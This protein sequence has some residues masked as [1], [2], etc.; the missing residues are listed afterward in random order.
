MAWPKRS[1]KKE[2]PAAQPSTR[3]NSTNVGCYDDDNACIVRYETYSDFLKVAEEHSR[4]EDFRTSF[5]GNETRE[6][7]IRY[8]RY[9]N[10]ALVENAN[11]LMDKLDSVCGGVETSQWEPSPCG[12]YPIVPEYL[13][14]SPT[15][16]RQMLPC[17]ELSPVKIYVCTTSSALV[18][19]EN[20]RKRGIAILAL[21][22]K[23]QAIRPVELYVTAETDGNG[24]DVIQV[25]PI[26]SKP[27]SLAH[28]TY[29]LTSAGFARRLTY[30]IAYGKYACM[31]GWGTMYDRL[32]SGYPEWLKGQLGCGPSDLYIKSANCDDDMLSDPVAW[33][34][35]E[36]ER[37]RGENA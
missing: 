13:N 16:M 20:L 17:G 10:E 18:S 25:I 33:V 8:A 19:A 1:K 37:F 34:N 6:E 21:V 11:K 27:L 29:C 23:L 35:R 2:Q 32:G 4:P 36:L 28:A 5:F 14:G 7:T 3:Y 24:G 31:G 30:G 9:G 12:A 22:M 26:E 15:C